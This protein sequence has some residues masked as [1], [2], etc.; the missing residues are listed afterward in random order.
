M[1]HFWD[2]MFQFRLFDLAMAAFEWLTG[3][4]LMYNGERVRVV[5]LR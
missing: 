1:R 4:W 5:R 3:K 2:W